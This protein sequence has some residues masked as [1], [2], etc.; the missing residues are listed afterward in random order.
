MKK[1]II[2][3]TVSFCFTGCVSNYHIQVFSDDVQA[4]PYK[5]EPKVVASGQTVLQRVSDGLF[6]AHDYES[7]MVMAKEAGYTKVLSVE[8]YTTSYFSLIWFIGEKWVTIRCS[9]EPGPEPEAAIP[10]EAAL[11]AES[12]QTP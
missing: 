9:K 3:I 12:T 7:A 1:L 11:S 6:T 4:L 5:Y 8:Y 10:P 2:L